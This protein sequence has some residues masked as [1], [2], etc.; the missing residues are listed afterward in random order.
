MV[1][2][3]RQWRLHCVSATSTWP[4]SRGLSLAALLPIRFP[5][6][7]CVGVNVGVRSGTFLKRWPPV[8]GWLAL[9]ADGQSA[10][11]AEWRAGGGRTSGSGHQGG[12]R[13]G[14]A[15]PQGALASLTLQLRSE[16][17]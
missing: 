5:I 4:A 3:G 15:C 17:T 13:D 6:A 1:T 10:I 12:R 16:W 14:I 2:S 7:P 9:V 11:P 8:R